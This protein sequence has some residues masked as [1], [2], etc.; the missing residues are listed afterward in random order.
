MKSM[1]ETCFVKPT[2]II[3]RGVMRR[4]HTEVLHVVLQ[5]LIRGAILDNQVSLISLEGTLVGMESEQL[6]HLML[7]RPLRGMEF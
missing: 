2:T 4:N 7:Y 3:C 5:G 6:Q 1:S